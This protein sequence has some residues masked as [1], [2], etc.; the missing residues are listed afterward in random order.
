MSFYYQPLR[1][2]HPPNF[3]LFDTFVPKRASFWAHQH[4]QAM[5]TPKVTKLMN[6]LPKRMAPQFRKVRVENIASALRRHKFSNNIGVSRSSKLPDSNP[7]VPHGEDRDNM[8]ELVASLD[9]THLYILTAH[10]CQMAFDTNLT[11][12]VMAQRMQ[13]IEDRD[14]AASRVRLKHRQER[15]KAERKRRKQAQ[16]DLRKKKQQEEEEAERLEQEHKRKLREAQQAK[17][18]PPHT[19]PFKPT[20]QESP[21]ATL[22]RLYESKWADLKAGNT[23]SIGHLTFMTFPWPTLERISGEVNLTFQNVRDFLL[24]PARPNSKDKSKKDILKEELLR[25]H[26]DKFI[27]VLPLVCENDREMVGTAAKTI[28]RLMMELLPEFT[29]V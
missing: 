29:R 2:P 16:D 27:K 5:K 28:G 13:K 10:R 25:W 1:V 9:S 18:S 17:V 20:F 8:E 4:T 19:P 6:D 26:P 22:Y 15:E 23:M 11:P 12:E 7:P 3:P 14:A 24:D 21:S